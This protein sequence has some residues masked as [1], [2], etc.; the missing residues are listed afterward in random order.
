M[1][2]ERQ[3]KQT[4]VDVVENVSKAYYL[5]LI[6]K[7]NVEYLGRDFQTLDTLLR[8]TRAMYESGFAEKLDVSRLQI[9]HNNL[10]TN[11]K[12]STELLVT[13]VNLLKFQMGMPIDSTN[14]LD[15]Y[16]DGG[17]GHSG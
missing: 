12:N 13:S 7:E 14:E 6:S 9:Q 16:T 1:L 11:L 10:R 8:E 4:E 17:G 3:Q 15:G 2:S 5:V